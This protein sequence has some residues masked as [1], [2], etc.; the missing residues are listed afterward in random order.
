MYCWRFAQGAFSRQG[1]FF[2]QRGYSSIFR[3]QQSRLFVLMKSRWAEVD[4]IL[5]L[6]G[7]VYAIEATAVKFFPAICAASVRSGIIIHQW[8]NIMPSFHRE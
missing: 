6:N 4:F 7:K 2:G 3:S 8:N 5:Q 1:L